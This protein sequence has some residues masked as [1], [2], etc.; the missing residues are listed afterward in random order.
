MAQPITWKTINAPDLSGASS[1]L[2]QAGQSFNNALGALERTKNTFEEGRTD[3]NTQAFMDQL[4][5]Y[6][7]PEELAAAQK[8]GD[9]TSLRDQFGS[10]IDQ[11]KVGTDA[12]QKR[13]GTMQE[14]VTRDYNYEQT[15]LEREQAPIAR[16][17]KLAIA[18]DD[19]ATVQRLLD[20]NP[21]LKNA[22]GLMNQFNEAERTRLVQGREDRTYDQETLMNDL[23]SR[24]GAAEGDRTDTQRV[25][26]FEA[27]A[28]DQGLDPQYIDQGVELLKGGFERKTQ[29]YGKDKQD[30][31]R[32][33]T[34]LASKYGI[35]RSAFQGWDTTNPVE[36][37]A[38]VLK[39]FEQTDEDGNKFLFGMGDTED[40]SR[41]AREVTDAMYNGV[42]VPGIGRVPITREVARLALQGVRGGTFDFDS[43]F[44]KEVAKLVRDGSLQQDFNNYQAYKDALNDLETNKMRY[45]L[46]KQDEQTPS[47]T[48]P[49][50]TESREAPANVDGVPAYLARPADLLK[51][52]G[53]PAQPQQSTVAG[54]NRDVPADAATPLLKRRLGPLI[55][56]GGKAVV[57]APGQVMD[58]MGQTLTRNQEQAGKQGA[59]EVRKLL[60]TNTRLPKPEMQE[61]LIRNPFLLQQLSAK[62]LNTLRDQYG[63]SFINQFIK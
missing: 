48:A 53:T 51:P 2:S 7:T 14:Q 45:A 27:A 6:Q 21:N 56:Q 24:I 15:Q 55:E 59:V 3:R 41:I 34:S 44:Q 25:Q 49:K 32:A 42:E 57:D 40:R 43:T 38:N 61:K 4:R 20:E 5:Q 54:S 30:Y 31:E 28:I 12:I 35:G 52:S 50:Q 17:I 63:E 33:K 13:I 26:A 60:D 39:E 47:K 9:I 29:L 22:P 37:S 19:D 1:I 8:A 10:L 36:D 23:V 46:G 58:W 16:Q 18:Q 62:E 11:S